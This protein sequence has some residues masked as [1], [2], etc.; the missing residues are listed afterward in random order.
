MEATRSDQNVYTSES[1]IAEENSKTMSF[2]EKSLSSCEHVYL[3][4]QL[5]PKI[6]ICS[7]EVMQNNE[8]TSLMTQSLLYACSI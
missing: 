2:G 3:G 8:M 4:K 1:E 7:E 5:L 6:D